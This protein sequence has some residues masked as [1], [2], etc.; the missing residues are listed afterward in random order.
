MKRRAIVHGLE[1]ATLR[2]ATHVT[3]VC[4]FAARREFV[5]RH[6]EKFVGPILNGVRS[7]VALPSRAAKSRV[8]TWGC[9]RR[10]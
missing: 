8:L 10:R 2:M 7:P 9:H 1:P 6:A 3:T 4:E 5:R